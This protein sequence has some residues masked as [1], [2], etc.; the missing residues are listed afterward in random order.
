MDAQV[1]SLTSEL[2]PRNRPSSAGGVRA[3]DDSEA[4]ASVVRFLIID[5]S[6]PSRSY[7]E[8]DVSRESVKC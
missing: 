3:N 2:R 5:L 6:V 7:L 1:E 4:L 8:M